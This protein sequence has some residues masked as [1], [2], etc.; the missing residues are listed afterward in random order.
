M[1]PSL[2]FSSN[3][4][5]VPRQFPDHISREFVIQSVVNRN[6]QYHGFIFQEAEHAWIDLF[7]GCPSHVAHCPRQKLTAGM[8]ASAAYDTSV[9][10]EGQA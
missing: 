9:L 5:P 3:A 4:Q 6:H 2:K 7:D 10:A 8:L 1:V